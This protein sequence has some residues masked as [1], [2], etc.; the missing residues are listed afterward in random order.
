MCPDAREARGAAPIRVSS[1]T[2]R[3]RSAIALLALLG[4]A[5]PGQGQALAFSAAPSIAPAPEVT[6]WPG[7][8][9]P[10][11]ASYEMNVRLDPEAK[12]ISG[13]EVLTWTNVTEHATDE[14]RYHLYYNAWKNGDS[15]WWTSGLRDRDALDRVRD[16]GWAY[17]HV[18][19]VALLSPAG[20][21]I[22]LE[23]EFIAPDDGN[24]RDRTVMRVRL[25]EPVA[26]GQEVRVRLRFT[27][28]VPRTFARTG[29]RGDYF[30]LAQWF[31]KVGVL[32]PDG[33]W[34][35]HQFIQTE[36]YAD[37]GVYDVSLTVPTGWTV[38]ATGRATSV[39][40]AGDGTTTH[41]FQQA[42]V[43]D[44]AWTTSPHFAEHTRT[45]RADGLP[46]VEMRLLVMPDH[47]DLVDRYFAATEAA[48]LHYGTW[49]G[50]YP[51]DHITIV[52]PAYGSQSGGM[53]YPTLFTGGARWLA[54]EAA[55]SPEGVTVHEAGHQ[56]WYGVVANNEFEHAWLDEGFNTY[57]TS[58]T[59]DHAFPEHAHVERYLE[60]FLPVV[61]PDI[62]PQD[63]TEGADR[64]AGTR[65]QLRRDRQ[66][67]HSWQTGPQGYHVNAYDKGAL[68]LRTLENHLGWETF[69]RVMSTYFR[70]QAFRHPVP[71]DFFATAERVSGQ[72]LAWFFDQ[73]WADAP[74]FDY[75]VD[76][77]VSKH[78]SDPR[79]Y[80]DADDGPILRPPA[81]PDEAEWL[82]H[83]YVRRWSDGRFPVEVAVTFDDGSRQVERW[84]GEDEWTELRFRTASKVARVEVDPDRVLVLDVDFSNN[85]WLRES[86]AD[87]AALKWSSKWIVW[88]QHAMEGLAFFS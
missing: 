5:S 43:H 27:A 41:R 66:S 3:P 11:N 21:E 63:R 45:F 37:F 61:F 77:V 22:P 70:E 34:N 79:G 67:R 7:R 51:Y 73:V 76:R 48:L 85:G 57:S 84:D 47:A 40:D 24:E 33:R 9:S 58:R 12:T 14:L 26:P 62:V 54:P 88:V 35:C 4:A 82:S 83:V 38:G 52:D 23:P 49:W 81:E 87:I 18:H 86:E 71:A 25:P 30:F 72:D 2:V 31:P 29:Y 32:E 28:K 64:H 13:E 78:V 69:Q 80:E 74:T 60:G 59:M 55:R 50:A 36:F 10:R 1:T 53:E 42:D 16:D 8:K 6:D 15:S 56:F 17:Q 44:F 75:A 65:S 68:T 39:T 20:E 46:E 19:E